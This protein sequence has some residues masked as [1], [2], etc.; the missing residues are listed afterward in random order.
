M[1]ST[2]HRVSLDTALQVVKGSITKYRIPAPV[3]PACGV[4]LIDPLCR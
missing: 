3:S 2:G 1:V 4:T